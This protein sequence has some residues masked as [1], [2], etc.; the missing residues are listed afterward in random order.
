MY[1]CACTGYFSL[2]T[3][4]FL[5]AAAVGADSQLVTAAVAA[6]HPALYRTE[7]RSLVRLAAAG[8]AGRRSVRRVR[9]QI[10]AGDPCIYGTRTVR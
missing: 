5:A 2:L 6:L 1:V 9:I 3:G 10:H 8:R 7:A 4:L